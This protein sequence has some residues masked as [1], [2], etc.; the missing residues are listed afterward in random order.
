MLRQHRF[1]PHEAFFEL[2]N[3]LRADSQNLFGG[4]SVRLSLAALTSFINFQGCVRTFATKTFHDSSL[5]LRVKR[6]YVVL[7][8]KT[9]DRAPLMLSRARAPVSWQRCS[10]VSKNTVEIFLCS[11]FT[12][13]ISFAQP[14]RSYP[15]SL[16]RL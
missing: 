12:C 13:S 16:T 14:M 9:H 8:C 6:F 4:M 7:A 15:P 3:Q 10:R 5:G 1:H 2:Q 11:G